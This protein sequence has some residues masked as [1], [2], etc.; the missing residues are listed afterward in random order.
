MNRASNQRHVYTV[1]TTDRHAECWADCPGLGLPVRC[2]ATGSLYVSTVCIYNVHKLSLCPLYIHLSTSAPSA[3]RSSV[4]GVCSYMHS[5]RPS[6]RRREIIRRWR[7]T[8]CVRNVDKR[9]QTR[10]SSGQRRRKPQN[11]QFAAERRDVDISYLLN[12]YTATYGRTDVRCGHGGHWTVARLTTP[13]V[14]RPP[15]EGRSL[16]VSV[17]CTENR[18]LRE[19]ASR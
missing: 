14:G 15:V 9:K 5:V 2:S 12:Q 6:V 19:I 11:C 17:I 4:D 13:S 10:H 18:R 1:Q 8:R 16:M 7:P 3:V